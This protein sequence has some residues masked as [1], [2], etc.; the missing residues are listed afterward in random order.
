MMTAAQVL[1]AFAAN[2][3]FSDIPDDVVARAKNCITDAM[4]GAI[5]GAQL[6]WSS[7]AIDY[8]MR[9]GTGGSAPI[10]GRSGLKTHALSAALANGVVIHAGRSDGGPIPS[11]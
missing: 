7:R 9:N 11:V 6:P 10:L 2:L 3:K 1:G 5:Y 4:G 8:A